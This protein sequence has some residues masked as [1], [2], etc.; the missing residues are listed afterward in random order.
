MPTE[1]IEDYYWIEQIL[2]KKKLS[3]F[4]IV[5]AGDLS[6]LGLSKV[7]KENVSLASSFD[8]HNLY[9]NGS[10][11]TIDSQARK[12]MI[13]EWIN[14]MLNQNT[15]T[16]NLILCGYVLPSDLDELKLRLDIEV[17]YCLLHPDT[18][19]ERLLLQEI[20]LKQPDEI[21][22]IISSSQEL[23][24][25]TSQKNGHIVTYIRDMLDHYPS[26]LIDQLTTW[27]NSSQNRNDNFDY[28]DEFLQTTSSTQPTDNNPVDLSSFNISDLLHSEEI[29]ELLAADINNND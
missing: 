13:N 26:D 10:P 19:N 8:I 5:D 12:N 16:Q 14:S 18:D 4:F 9:E 27:L 24:D 6:S 23:L 20:E 2:S 21:N 28:L 3:I 29:T 7:L 25:Q 15:A 22:E 11:S 17:H 1:N